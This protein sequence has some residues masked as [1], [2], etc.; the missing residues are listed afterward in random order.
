M[1]ANDFVNPDIAA[2]ASTLGFEAYSAHDNSSFDACLEALF[3]SGLGG[4][5]PYLL[6]LKIDKNVAT[7][8]IDRAY[9]SYRPP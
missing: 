5:K 1:S 3:A 4:P 9:H 2:V 6:C 8:E 7:P